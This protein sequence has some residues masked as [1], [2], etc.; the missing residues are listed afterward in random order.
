M[1]SEVEF[2]FLDMEGEG[3]EP[4]DELMKGECVCVMCVSECVWECDQSAFQGL[5]GAF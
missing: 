2:N 5:S 4:A 1:K 3:V